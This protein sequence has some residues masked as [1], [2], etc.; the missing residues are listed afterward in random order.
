MSVHLASAGWG[1]SLFARS[2]RLI[3]VL[4]VAAQFA[5]LLVL[6][7]L[8]QRPRLDR[9]AGLVRADLSAIDLALHRLPQSERAGYVDALNRAAAGRI[10]VPAGQ[11]PAQF[12]APQAPAAALLLRPLQS[13]LGSGFRLHWARSGEMRLWIGTRL[14]GQR[15]WVGFATPGLLT[16]LRL[17]LLLG[18]AISV[19]LAVLG[20]WIIHRTVR[21]PMRALA[22]AAEAVGAGRPPGPLPERV[23]PEI[24][25]V[26]GSF[27][28]MA[29][30]LERA[31]RD[32][33]VMLAGVSHDLRTPLAKLRLCVEMLPPGIDAE[34][35]ATMKR[36]IAAADAI[37]SQFLDFAR[38]GADESEEEVDLAAL[39]RQTALD[40]LPPERLDLDLPA[41][42]CTL[43]ARPVALRRAVMNL[44][45]NA[46]THAG[47][48]VGLRLYC[49]PVR[50][51]LAVLDRGPGIAQDRRERLMR[52]FA[53]GDASAGSGLGLAVVDRVARLHRGSLELRDRPGGGLEAVLRLPR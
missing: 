50:A 13:A 35:V 11:A 40:L 22:A 8:V 19:A 4:L 37:V 30:E 51:Q 5:N 17:P 45:D 24:A 15:Y 2:L 14:G 27:A 28:R 38:V 3:I 36:S 20:A 1:S 52:P 31:D 10:L 18:T 43:R 34:L 25:Q 23:P 39:A 33:A 42:G 48:I 47:G 32:R 53:R 41:S 12:D 7:E 26:V 6:R 49:D 46:V 16:S 9:L 44:V 21:R 29:E